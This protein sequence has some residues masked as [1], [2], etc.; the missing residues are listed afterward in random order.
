M[1]R[2]EMV[3]LGPLEDE[4]EKILYGGEL[5]LVGAWGMRRKKGFKRRRYRVGF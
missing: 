5:E 1:E 3:L 4:R 2:A